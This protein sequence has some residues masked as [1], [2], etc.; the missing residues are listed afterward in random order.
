MLHKKDAQ[1]LH[2]CFSS[3]AIKNIAGQ[4]LTYNSINVHCLNKKGRPI[5]DYK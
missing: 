3:R 2:N 4:V 5:T 1:V